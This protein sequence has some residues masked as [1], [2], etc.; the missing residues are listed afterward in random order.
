MDLLSIF[1]KKESAQ[2][3]G[4]LPFMIGT[5]FSPYKLYANKRSAASLSI[6]LKNLKSE[7][8]MA[9]VHIGL[10]KNISFSEMGLSKEKEIKL[11]TMNANE[12]KEV[13]SE[14]LG[15]IGTDTGTYTITVTAYE[16]YRDYDHVLNSVSKRIT[17]E[18]V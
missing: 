13:R 18:V 2:N 16:H 6:R 15:D 9:S 10:P 14:V 8:V 17:L 5:E 7:P 1:R 3:D 4:K 11:G 12:E